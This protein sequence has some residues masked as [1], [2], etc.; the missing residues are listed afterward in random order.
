M[1]FIYIIYDFALQVT[2]R[3]ADN[4]LSRNPFWSQDEQWKNQRA[5]ILGGLTQNRVIIY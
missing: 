1:I 4:I 3:Q 5:D 2:D